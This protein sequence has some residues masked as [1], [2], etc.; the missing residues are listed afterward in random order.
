MARFR[1][2]PPSVACPEAEILQNLPL[3]GLFRGLWAPLRGFSFITRERLWPFV[4]LPTL[5][6]AA[7][8]AVTFFGAWRY[9]RAE[10]FVANQSSSALRVL[11]AVLLSAV[12]GAALFLVAHPILDAVFCDKLTEKVEHRVN[13]ASPSVPLRKAVIQALGHGLLK[14]ALYAFALLSGLLLGA[15]TGIG[16]VAG[17]ALGVIF[18]AYD[19]FDYP[20]ARRGV[21][22]GAKWRYLA[23]HPGLTIGYGLATTLL[24]FVPLAI[25]VAPAI[26]ATGA[27]L[28]FLD[29]EKRAAEKRARRAEKAARAA[30]RRAQTEERNPP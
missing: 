16:G 23:L 11:M 5:L 13:G 17:L 7:L 15:L 21:G 3:M 25:V 27:T 22:F 24:Y 4:F 1:H 30:E 14:S 6:D 2:A 29:V 10:S 19:G 12:L 26:S 28:A 18:L 8:A 9:W 20:L